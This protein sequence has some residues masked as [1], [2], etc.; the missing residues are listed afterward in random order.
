MKKKM[1]LSVAAA[2]L[3]GT[4][5]VGGTLAY[6]TDTETATNTIT[7]GNVDVK[8]TENDPKAVDS[9]DGYTS[10]VNEDNEGIT[11]SDVEPGV[12][13]AKAPVITYKGASRGYVRYKVE[14]TVTPKQ[15]AEFTNDE[16]TKI[17]KAVK[18]YKD[19]TQRTDLT[20][21]EYKYAR[22]AE[23]STTDMGTPF[24]AGDTVEA[25]FDHVELSK[26]L[27]NDDLKNL[28]NI[29]I[30]IVADAIQADNL[31]AN[32]DGKTTVDEV[33]AAFGNGSVAEYID[34]KAIE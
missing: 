19:G 8:I 16:K 17:E 25:L 33:E 28:G 13:I 29:E 27:G 6:F 34:D 20:V 18:F 30:K 22:L 32:S 24:Q 3:V 7:T 4:L 9:K 14:V 12:M 15:G 26:E 21:G 23:N 11:Y 10:K 1:A 2:A 31:D 5:A